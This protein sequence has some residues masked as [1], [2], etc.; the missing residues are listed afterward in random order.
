MSKAQAQKPEASASK[1]ESGPDKFWEFADVG[2]D[3]GKKLWFIMFSDEK[4]QNV[5]SYFAR[6][7]TLTGG[8]AIQYQWK[9]SQGRAF[10]HVRERFFAEDI[11]GFSIEPGSISIKFRPGRTPDS[12]KIP[13]DYSH[14]LYAYHLTNKEDNARAPTGFM[15]FVNV[16]GDVIQRVNNRWIVIEDLS[17][18]TSGEYPKIRLR[19]DK[20]DVKNIILSKTTIIVQGNG[21]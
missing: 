19:I 12:L 4:N 8:S 15:D 18:K 7:I 1:G 14:I 3:T 5:G 10:W 13:D 17:R 2:F 9:D 16:R 21:E 6:N 20:K 11:E